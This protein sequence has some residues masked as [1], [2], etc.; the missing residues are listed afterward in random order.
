[1]IRYTIHDTSGS[2]VLFILFSWA[3]YVL[4]SGYP[5]DGYALIVVNIQAS[6]RCLS[7]LIMPHH[8]N[9]P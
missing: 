1:M 6:Y 7:A 8:R 4:I 3:F 2:C 9:E 5:R